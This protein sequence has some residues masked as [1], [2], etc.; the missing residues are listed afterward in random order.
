MKV[1]NAEIPPDL[2]NSVSY[3]LN[4]WR[5]VN[6]APRI[7]TASPAKL[8]KQHTAGNY[9]LAWYAI[10]AANRL[11]P[12]GNWIGTAQGLLHV[13]QKIFADIVSDVWPEEIWQ[14]CEQTS[15]VS[16]R[17]D[18]T[19]I[20]HPV[21]TPTAFIVPC[22]HDCLCTASG[23]G[24]VPGFTIS[25][26]GHSSQ[27]LRNTGTCEEAFPYSYFHTLTHVQETR[28]FTLPKPCVKKDQVPLFL[29]GDLTTWA[30]ATNESIPPYS[31]ARYGL[32]PFLGHLC[33][34]ALYHDT[35]PA[36]HYGNNACLTGRFQ[37][38]PHKG[39]T[40]TDPPPEGPWYGQGDTLHI[41][42]DLT[43]RAAWHHDPA[44]NATTL[45]VT[46]NPPSP[47][48]RYRWPWQNVDVVHQYELTAHQAK[49]LPF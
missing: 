32:P 38:K 9:N 28:I 20:P 17:W 12:L 31:T 16:K 24:Y 8:Y 37:L 13:K 5:T 25:Y 49:M 4:S 10:R 14:T 21:P 18:L 40:A 42:A 33:I 27:T 44:Q 45:L 7:F 34:S 36:Q 30:F 11:A 6:A 19:C 48:G 43:T 2:A 3:A 35:L 41:T 46:L 22:S 47:R 29:A 1:C 26:A 39:W 23:P 15:M